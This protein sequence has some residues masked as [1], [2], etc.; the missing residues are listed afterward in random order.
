M[1]SQLPVNSGRPGTISFIGPSCVQLL[2][3]T[4]LQSRIF[5]SYMVDAHQFLPENF[6]DPGNILQGEL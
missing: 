1:Q 3:Q 6:F 5:N 2:Y 4:N